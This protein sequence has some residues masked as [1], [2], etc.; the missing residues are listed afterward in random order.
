[1]QS[2]AAHRAG[3]VRAPA[4]LL[5]ALGIGVGG[6]PPVGSAISVPGEARGEIHFTADAGLFLDRDGK[7][8]VYFCLAVPLSEL[9]CD[10]LAD[11]TGSWAEIRVELSGLDADGEARHARRQTLDLPCAETADAGG[12]PRRLVHLRAPWPMAGTDFEVRVIDQNALRT[13]LIYQLRGEERRG[14]LQGSLELPPLA[15]DRGLSS[16]LYLWDFEPEAF[17][18]RGGLRIAPADSVR[19]RI[20]PNPSASFGLRR[21]TLVA[22]AE[23]YGAMGSRYEVRAR[24][25]SLSDGKSVLNDR[26]DLELPWART[27]LVYTCD[28]AGLLTGTYDL[29][30]TLRP[31]DGRNGDL[32]TH[33]HFQMLW[34]P[35]SWGASQASQVEEMRLLLDPEALERYRALEPGAREAFSESLWAEADGFS[36]PGSWSGPA[37]AL[38]AERVEVADRRFDAALMRG[39]QTDRGRVFVRFGEPDE[40][41][42]ELLPLERDQIANFME[43]AVGDAGRLD[44]ESVL[45]Q[46]PLD[47]SAYEVWYYVHRGEPLMPD[48]EP[49]GRGHS[50]TFIFADRLGNGQYRLIY[51]NLYGGL[52]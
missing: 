6:T 17:Q 51:T 1:V 15:A 50:L 32:T 47:A 30:L 27:A 2:D 37:R 48:A 43:E 49:P 13:G 23:C 4:L 22:Y 29:E 45:K 20:E 10:S 25:R 7:P 36:L 12:H 44:G 8:E 34:R 38:F 24:I 40:V 14:I 35:E 19:E 9:R 21:E 31:R 42:K 39:S 16:C 52:R 26:A 18:R 5:L 11:R 46:N 41:K 28:V 33:A 3:P